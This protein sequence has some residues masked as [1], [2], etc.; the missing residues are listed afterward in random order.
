MLKGSAV[1]SSG[2]IG[3]TTLGTRLSVQT[4]DGLVVAGTMA[5]ATASKSTGKTA[6]V[7]SNADS[8]SAN[9]AH[10][11]ASIWTNGGGARLTIDTP[12]T[13]DEAGIKLIQSKVAR[14]TASGG[15]L[16]GNVA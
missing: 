15:T 13:L 3:D 12:G 5:T 9:A 7:I 6:I 10:A 1:I 4:Q 2:E 8:K 11:P 14:L 16:S